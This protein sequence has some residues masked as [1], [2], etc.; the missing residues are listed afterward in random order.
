MAIALAALLAQIAL[1]H[2][3]RWQA[4]DHAT[5]AR[6]T[7]LRDAVP[8][9]A[10]RL[11]RRPVSEQIAG[12]HVEARCSVCQAIAQARSYVSATT[13]L[14]APLRAGAATRPRDDAGDPAV[15]AAAHPARSPP[16]D[17]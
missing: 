1:P 13:L 10:T 8:D 14:P 2:L 15:V 11:A 16:R 17:A 12:E 7:H 9:P 3:H 4:G 5:A 6:A